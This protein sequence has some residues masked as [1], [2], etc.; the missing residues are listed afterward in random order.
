M[1]NDRMRQVSLSRPVIDSNGLMAFT[2][3]QSSLVQNTRRPNPGGNK[4]G[5]L[6]SD[7]SA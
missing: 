7:Q 6:Q 5:S 3:V 1:G 2:A 4:Y